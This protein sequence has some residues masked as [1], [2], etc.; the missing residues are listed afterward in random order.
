MIIA[1]DFDG[2]IVSQDRPYDDVE[3]SLTF[4]PGAKEGLHALKRAGHKLVLWSGRARLSLRNNDPT[5]DPLFNAGV[6]RGRA[7]RNTKVNEARFVQMVDFVDEELPGIFDYVYKGGE[8]D[9]PGVDMFIDNIA[10]K[11]GGGYGVNWFQIK[12]MYGDI[13]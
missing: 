1:I 8:C 10:V 9:K 12:H 13:L 7:D 2:T 6:K 4:L 11:L 3:T 5:L